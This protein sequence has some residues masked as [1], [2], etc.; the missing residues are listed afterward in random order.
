MKYLGLVAD[1]GGYAAGE[2]SELGSSHLFTALFGPKIA[3]R[4]GPFTPFA[5]ALVGVAHVNI[6]GTP[7]TIAWSGGL[8]LD[9]NLSHHWGVRVA[10]VEYLSTYFNDGATDHQNNIRASAGIVYRF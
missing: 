4:A 5:Q 6:S 10:Q 1:F 9:F 3:L 7:N 2:S 8:G